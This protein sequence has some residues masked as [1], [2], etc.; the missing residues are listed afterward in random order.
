MW[1]RS[2]NPLGH[3]ESAPGLRVDGPRTPLLSK[4]VLTVGQRAILD[5][6]LGG[7]PPTLALPSFNQTLMVSAGSNPVT[8]TEALASL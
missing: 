1:S 8:L 3:D 4:G 5:V 2:R 7:S 6:A